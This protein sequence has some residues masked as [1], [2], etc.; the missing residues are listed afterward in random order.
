MDNIGTGG[1]FANFWRGLV[2]WFL[3]VWST[4]LGWCRSAWTTL[5]GI[6]RMPYVKIGTIAAVILIAAGI[7]FFTP[8]GMGEQVVVEVVV[9]FPS[10][11]Y[12]HCPSGRRFSVD[13]SYFNENGQVEIQN[14]TWCRFNAYLYQEIMEIEE[15]ETFSFGS[16]VVNRT[17]CLTDLQGEE[18]YGRSTRLCHAF[19]RMA[20]AGTEPLYLSDGLPRLVFRD[21]KRVF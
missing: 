13:H 17:Q 2:G 7:Y 11:S 19:L 8:Y 16:E 12:E 3:V 15:D 10:V 18:T 4:L 20:T 6:W 9:E 21:L 1:Q 5:L 14:D